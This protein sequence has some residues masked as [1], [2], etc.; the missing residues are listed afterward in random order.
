MI[1]SR[2][3]T[4]ALAV[5]LLAFG[6]GTGSALAQGMAPA[7][8]FLVTERSA[9]GFDETLNLLRQAIEAEN[10]MVVQE[11]NPQ[12]MLRM[13]GVQIGGMRQVFFFHP[14][15]MKQILE[16]NRNAGI[17]PPLKVLIME[18]PNGQVMVRYE[19]PKHQ[20]GPYDGLE[21][22]SEELLGIFERVV[23][24]VTG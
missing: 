7:P 14:R 17:E 22:L 10:L 20:F 2:T 13:V 15:Y 8:D 5:F 12:Q 23:A 4:G 6:I 16:T 18:A 3:A 9:H 11:V 21:E 1:I 24:S 19:D